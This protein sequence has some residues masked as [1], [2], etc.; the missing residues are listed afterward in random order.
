MSDKQNIA[1]LGALYESQ[2]HSLLDEFLDFLRIPTISSEKQ[3]HEDTLN[4]ISWIEQFLSKTPLT[5]KRWETNGFPVFFAEWDGAGKEAPTVLLYNHYDVQP[6]D[7]LELWHSEPFAP[8]IR[9][10]EIYARGAQDNKGQCFYVISLI[11]A[12]FERDGSLPVNV[13]LL[14][15]GEEEIGSSGLAGILDQHKEELKA[16]HL[17]IV[18]FGFTDMRRPSVCMGMRG[19]CT[20]TVKLK[21]SNSDLHSGVH[22]GIVYNTNHALIEIL[23]G[24][25]DAN[26]KITIPGFYDGVIALSDLEK[27]KINFDF[28]ENDYV[29]MFDAQPTGG[30]K[31]L[32]PL[33]S[34]WTRPTLEINGIA[35]GYHGN[36]FKTVIPKEALAKISCRTVVGQDPWKVGELVKNYILEKLPKGITAEIT[37]HPG[38]GEAVRTDPNSEVMQAAARAFSEVLGKDCSITLEGASVPIVAN[39][40]KVS[41][42]DVA[43]IGYGL[44]G[45]NIHAPNEHFGLDR[46]KY[47]FCAI[48]RILE[49]LGSRE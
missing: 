48:G 4:G 22:G 13:K 11:R 39:L 3:F 32:S 1:D 30:E 7:P 12:L 43:M 8:E 15:E 36:G 37:I 23:S 20:M 21:G 46:L 24:M 42:G 25:R 2:E 41:G 47:G 18:D 10:G 9:N 17:L 49:I 27:S 16:E 45:D 6:V 29:K 31:N 34:A 5:M 44:P 28:N 19:L 35:G 14:I 40:T 26:G 33:E 38:I